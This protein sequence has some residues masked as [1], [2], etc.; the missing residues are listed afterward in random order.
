MYYQ[1]F[2]I[3]SARS[4]DN[5]VIN[6]GELFSEYMFLLSSASVEYLLTFY[7]LSNESFRKFEF[8][9]ISKSFP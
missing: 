7:K 4:W 8:K 2:V 1:M 6:C 5:V 3:D 9:L